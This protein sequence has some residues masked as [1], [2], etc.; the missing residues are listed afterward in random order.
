MDKQETKQETKQASSLW[1]G[2]DS[3]LVLFMYNGGMSG[4]S[5]SRALRIPYSRV[6]LWLKQEGVELRKKATPKEG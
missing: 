3:K 6:L 4:L 1:G 5:I 2:A